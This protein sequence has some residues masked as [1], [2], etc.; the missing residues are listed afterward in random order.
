MMKIE[1]FVN[2]NVTIE[3]FQEVEKEMKKESL[4]EMKIGYSRDA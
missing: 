3:D 4:L 2:Q 1:A